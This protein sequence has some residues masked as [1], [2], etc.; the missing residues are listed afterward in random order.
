MENSP[1]CPTRKTVSEGFSKI[2]TFHRAKSLNQA[3]D[4]LSNTSPHPN[5]QLPQRHTN[6]S[7]TQENHR[8][9]SPRYSRKSSFLSLDLIVSPAQSGN[10]RGVGGGILRDSPPPPP[11]S[12]S[13]YLNNKPIPLHKGKRQW[14]GLAE[15]K[16]RF[17]LRSHIFRWPF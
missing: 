4:G 11:T 12:F 1:I 9:P 14:E 6:R 5:F 17:K 7:K 3:I 8:H 15:A 2:I 10:K 16:L 13:R